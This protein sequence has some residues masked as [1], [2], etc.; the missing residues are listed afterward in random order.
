MGALIKGGAALEALERV[1]TYVLDKTGTLTYGRLQVDRLIPH[2]DWPESRLRAVAAALA[3]SSNH[4]V[5]RAVAASS[6]EPLQAEAV[7]EIPGAGLE[8][9]VEG[10]R[11]R[12]G[13]ANFAGVEEAADR[14]AVY[15]SDEEGPLA[16]LV[17]S[18]KIKQEAKQAVEALSRDHRLLLVSGDRPENVATLA[19]S[20]GVSDW[21]AGVSP[22]QKVEI[23]R[24]LQETGP[25]AMVGDGVNDVAAL[26]ESDVGIAMGAA[27]TDA[28]VD[29]ADV[30][31]LN[32]DI[33]ALVRLD[34]LSRD[35]RS[36]ILQNIVFSLITKV[37]LVVVGVMYPLG[38]WVAVAGDMGVSLLVTA[39]SLRLR[40]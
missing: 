36:V 13:S 27:G 37:I 18:E 16:T 24:E 14:R 40:R 19:E 12:L 22:E 34:R 31:V 26:L 32:D 11:Y 3:A 25:V 30:I 5:A 39:N 21:R 15:L 8:G 2:R 7:E 28:A 38:F 6:D 4:P 35:L 29:A 10:R 33:S 1:R 20:I 9:V 17:L 23:V